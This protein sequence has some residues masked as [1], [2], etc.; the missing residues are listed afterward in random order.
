MTS[1]TSSGVRSARWLRMVFLLAVIC[2]C[3]SLTTVAEGPPNPAPTPEQR[4]STSLRSQSFGQRIAAL[5]NS[6]R[7]LVEVMQKELLH[8]LMRWVEYLAWLLALF[9]IPASAVREWHENAGKGRNLLWWFGRLAVCLLLFG[10]ATPIIDALYVV[11]KDIAE[12]NASTG[13]RSVLFDFHAKQRESF[14]TSYNKLVNSSFKVKGGVEEFT[15]KPADGS[16]P[17]MGNLYDQGATVRDLTSKLDDS[18]YTMTKLFTLMNISRG[19]MEAGD[20]WLIVL[21]GLLMLTFKMVAPLMVILGIDRKISQRTVTTYVWGLVIL[22]LVWPSVSYIL[23]TLAYMGGNL[24]MAMGDT[25]QIY[26]WTVASQKTMRDPL[27]QPFYTIVI[28]SLMMLGAGLALW[29]SPFIA[30]SIAMGRV[31]EGVAQQASQ[32]AG[33]IVSTAVEFVSA[34][35]GAKLGRQ[36]EN[37]QVEGASDAEQARARGEL[38]SS[39]F[40]AMARRAQ[41]AFNAKSQQI[42]LLSQARAALINQQLL[43]EAG[44]KFQNNSVFQQNQQNKRNWWVEQFYQGAMTRIG[45]GQQSLENNAGAI[46]SL[47]ESAGRADPRLGAAAP[48]GIL[49]GWDGRDDALNKGAKAR[50]AAINGYYNT[51][52]TV[53]QETG[54]VDKRTGKPFVKTVHIDSLAESNKI[55][56]GEM[57]KINAD[58]Q[59]DQGKAANA[60]FSQSAQG[61][62]RAYKYQL[63]AADIIYN[64]YDVPANQARFDAQMD[65]ARITRSA[66]LEAAN[67]RAMQHVLSQ[68]SSKV[69]REIEKNM[70]MRF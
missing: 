15:I 2:C 19:V 48:I 58:Y 30:Y 13:Q 1:P 59:T 54:G 33:S 7:Q 27:A 66:G 24:A 4:L 29:M 46:Q 62:D 37:A 39:N 45:F 42:G 17:F 64:D 61:I 34:N 67:F 50:L 23:S 18:S 31:F 38:S 40:Q 12:G 9:L 68:V 21:S 32:L 47:L 55:F 41:A 10:A 56:T 6:A 5:T 43:A 14:N 22:T 8:H 20:L 53:N 69:A 70:E 3:S 36:A 25:D 60:A 49:W 51:G 44:R 26:T 16:E 11:G 28:G 35:I 52:F 63:H 65:A 57:Y